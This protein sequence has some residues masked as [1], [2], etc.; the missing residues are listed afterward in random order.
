MQSKK[1]F[2]R[3]KKAL[4][5]WSVEES[6]GIKEMFETVSSAGFDGIELN[7]DARGGA[8]SLSLETSPHDYQD[9]ISC[10]EK[11]NLPVVSISTSM[12]GGMSGIPEAWEDYKK[13]LRKQIEAAKALGAPAILTVPGGNGAGITLKSARENSIRFYRSIREEVEASGIRIGLE[14]VWNGFFL[15]PYDMVSFLVQI[16]S[17][18]FGAYFDAGN[19]LA[20]SDP[21][22]WAEILADRIVCVHVKD[23]KRNQGIHSGGTWE[24]LLQGSAK[25]ENIILQ[26]KR[27]GFDGYLTGEVSKR[28]TFIPWD[29][30]YRT[31]SKAI[32]TIIRF[33]PK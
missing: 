21:E 12:S 33:A 1:G 28:D 26:L 17:D 29:E 27:S 13:L 31:V 15:S 7:I 5:A 4:N 14:N 16:D 18:A 25:W 22:D 6:T 19:V 30:Y 9:I 32:D 11:Y 3:M 23:F 2:V 24:N 8:H 10:V 20:F